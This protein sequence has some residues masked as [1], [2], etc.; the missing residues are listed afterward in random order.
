M[1]NDPY[2]SVNELITR[3]LAG[4]TSA[5]EE[6]ELLAWI[7]LSDG[8]RRHYQSLEKAFTLTGSHF[9]PRPAA[10]IPINVDREW[11]RFTGAIGVRK[12]R[13]LHPSRV[14]LRVAATVLLLLATGAI[15]YYF[16]SGETVAYH[17]AS[18]NEKITLPDGS[19]VV[20][21][22]HSSLSYDAGFGDKDR[23]VHLRG[24]AFFDVRPDAANP[25]VVVTDKATVRVLGTSFN[26]NA[27]DS[28]Q[29]VEVIVETGIVSLAS[30]DT[31][32]NVELAAGERGVYSK[33]TARISSAVNDD[34]NF[35]SWNTQRM[36]FRETG[37]RAVIETLEKTYDADITVDT[38]IP[39]S[40]LVT[41]TFDHQ[42]LESV[43]KVL[44]STLNLKYTL[45]GKKVVITEAGC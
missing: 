4:E 28:L 34:V 9:A 18:N 21:N 38:E 32:E 41:V 44:E 2:D 37:L 25:F 12:T 19:A 24:E 20:L 16:A 43:L 3:H 15:L 36:V 22:R 5:D 26:V 33:T 40:C 29:E 1:I 7:N 10:E 17:T 42:T 30:K 23:T 35:L 8:N 6:K 14:W 13:A 27:Y 39:S 45:D 11:E 31:D